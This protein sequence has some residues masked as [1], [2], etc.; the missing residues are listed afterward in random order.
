M[1]C[2]C[3]IGDACAAT[4]EEALGLRFIR[5]KV[6]IGKKYLSF[7]QHRDFR[8][9]WFLHLYD[10]LS[11]G[12]Y[13]GGACRDAGPRGFIVGIVEADCMAGVCLH[14]DLVI[15]GDHLSDTGRCQ[16]YTVLERFDFLGHADKHC[17]LL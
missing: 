4:I 5:G 12:E 8:S 9:L 11:L 16:A 14:H 15:I 10:H 17:K 1:I 13:I 3:F 7:A 2:H 6:Q